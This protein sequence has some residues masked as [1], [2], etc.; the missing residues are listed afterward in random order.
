VLGEWLGYAPDQIRQVMEV[1]P[2]DQP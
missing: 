1:A 2:A